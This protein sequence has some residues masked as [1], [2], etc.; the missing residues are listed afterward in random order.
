MSGSMRMMR[1]PSGCLGAAVFVA[2]LCIGGAAQAVQVVAHFTLGLFNVEPS[3]QVPPLLLP[4]LDT[5]APSGGFSYDT[6]R[7]SSTTPPSPPLIGGMPRYTFTDPGAASLFVTLNGYTYSTTSSPA[8]PLIVQVTGGT[9][10]ND[11]FGITA[12][13]MLPDPSNPLAAV[14][15]LSL[16]NANGP[17]FPDSSLPTSDFRSASFEDPTLI[18]ESQQPFNQPDFYRLFFQLKSDVSITPVP[19]PPGLAVVLLAAALWA[20][21]RVRT[22]K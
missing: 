9:P 15:R 3:E 17:A 5:S 2:V 22:I 18:L 6:A 8:N 12:P 4:P 21:A 10:F 20:A 1:W 16:V 11:F 14:P 13:N 19:E 7:V